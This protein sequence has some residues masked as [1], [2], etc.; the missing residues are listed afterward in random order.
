MKHNKQNLDA[1]IDAAAR[2]VRDE[3]IDESVIDQSAT[4]VWARISSQLSED[5]S[6]S[7]DEHTGNV[8]T[9]N[10]KNSAEQIDGCADFQTLI[11][12]YLDKKLSTARTLLLEDHT[13]ECIP[14]RRAL[15]KQRAGATPPAVVRQP[16]PRAATEPKRAFLNGWNRANVV[17][18]S[19]AAVFAVCVCMAGMFA[20]ERFDWSGRTLAATLE[21]ANGAVYVVSDAQESRQLAPGDLLQKGE[22]VRTAKD[23]SAGRDRPAGARRRDRRSR[24]AG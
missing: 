14:C 19:A 3:R 2:E 15:K 20:F 21:D 7:A 24:Q 11:P 8:N 9:M 5:N 4:R 16:A 12:A 10:I 1:I 23:S 22:R 6:L 13:N 18:W 17:R